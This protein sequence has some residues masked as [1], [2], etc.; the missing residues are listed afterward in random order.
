M[1]LCLLNAVTAA[2]LDA[3]VWPAQYDPERIVRD[4]IQ[5]L[6]RRAAVRLRNG[7]T[8]TFTWAQ[9]CAKFE[10]LVS[11]SADTD[12]RSEIIAAVDALDALPVTDLT[13]LL[14]QAG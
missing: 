3:E 10:R 11:K 1:R 8:R 5:R 4:D 13:R 12:L 7:E 6:L 9:T 2:L 14:A